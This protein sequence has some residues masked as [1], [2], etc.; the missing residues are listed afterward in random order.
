[1]K[2]NAINQDIND[3][4]LEELK[5]SILT[6]VKDKYDMDSKKIKN[7]V[8]EFLQSSKDRLIRWTVL[9][10]EKSITPEEYA[11]LLT[12]Q[13]DEFV[14]QSLYQAGI[15]RISLGHLKNKIIDV[16]IDTV[17]RFLTGKV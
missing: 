15:S 2:E 17:I 13:K 10:A 4:L 12:A 11:L 16:I 7:E 3:N 5:S 6:L 14:I 9:L 8:E 1:M